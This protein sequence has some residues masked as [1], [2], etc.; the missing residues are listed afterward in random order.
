MATY[1]VS[2]SG[3]DG[4]N[5]T[6]PLT[7]FATL[8][9]AQSIL[10]AG[11]TLLLNYGSRW[12]ETLTI[13]QANVTVDSY[14][15]GRIFDAVGYVLNAP[16]VDGGEGLGGWSSYASGETV[17]FG[18]DS[19][20]GTSGASIGG[21]TPT[22]GLGWV[23]QA[24]GGTSA[25]LL[26]GSGGVYATATGSTTYLC[27]PPN[28]STTGILNPAYYVQAN[29]TFKTI[30]A[31]DIG[32]VCARGQAG[33]KT[34][35]SGYLDS[36]GNIAIQKFANGTP[37]TVVGPTNVQT[38]VA[39]TAYTLKL[40]VVGNTV[41]LF[42]N[43]TQVG[44]Y[45][46]PSPITG[47]TAL[48]Q[49]GMPG[50][51][52]HPGVAAETATTGLHI[53]AFSCGPLDTGTA[54]N[55][56]Q[57]TLPTQ[58]FVVDYNGTYCFQGVGPNSLQD[59]EWYWYANKLYFR[60]DSGAPATGS[61]VAS[62]SDSCITATGKAGLTVQNVACEHAQLPAF[63]FSGCTGLT[64]QNCYG[65]RSSVSISAVHGILALDGASTNALIQNNIFRQVAGTA[66]YMTPTC[67]GPLTVQFNRLYDLFEGISQGIEFTNTSD[68]TAK[69]WRGNV[70][71][72][73]YA[74]QVGEYSNSE[75]G[76]LTFFG[77]NW[78]VERNLVIG[79][80]LY[81][82]THP[83]NN[84]TVRDNFYYRCGGGFFYTNLG[85]SGGGGAI[86]TAD[87]TATVYTGLSAY[88][89]VMLDCP[90][91]PWVDSATTANRTGFSYYNNLILNLNV[92]PGVQ[93]EG[94]AAAG[95]YQ[96]FFNQAMSGAF[97]NNVVYDASGA[98]TGG[99][100]FKSETALNAWTSD[101]NVWG[102]DAAGKFKFK[103]TAYD[104]LAAYQAGQS[105]DQHSINSTPTFYLSDYR[106]PTYPDLNEV[107]VALASFRNEW[108][109]PA[110]HL[111]IPV[112][113][114]TQ[115]PTP[116]AGVEATYGYWGIAV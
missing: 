46:D 110:R 71:T 21:H 53:S 62:Q 29:V 73:P 3:S 47:G 14:G 44:Q 64:V 41:T 40:T 50:I 103:S 59:N 83:G 82:S 23:L 51:L 105:R 25:V 115:M 38:I 99:L 42:L 57:T 92:G 85:M 66:I 104:T 48:F 113:G 72:I 65:Q 97:E 98:G 95:S 17:F 58:P 31:G 37:G 36:A 86:R 112:S 100:F 9:H 78:L 7:P 106:P 84:H 91:G 24:N 2:R 10:A 35:Y 26:D 87:N 39:G 89:N 80:A 61:V 74:A 109:S 11:D 108:R 13:P 34:M 19:F 8:A 67:T 90:V 16:I 81:G 60:N 20:A 69:V 88:R 56:F 55:T 30:V 79:G 70:V 6:S 77:D 54:A 101:H 27:Q 1:Y 45:T 93:N 68:S 49:P 111:G 33:T 96:A 114:V 15:A 28:L 52:L 32:A 43:G 22:V 18:E 4:N 12:F 76:G 63:D 94:G 107:F 102:P 5:G 75:K 116:D